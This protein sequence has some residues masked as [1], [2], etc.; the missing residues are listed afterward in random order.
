MNSGAVTSIPRRL[1]TPSAVLLAVVFLP[2]ECEIAA[3]FLLIAAAGQVVGWWL[4]MPR[5]SVFDRWGPLWIAT[6]FGGIG[7]ALLARG[8]FSATLFAAGYASASMLALAA[9][10]GK[11]M[12]GCAPETPFNRLALAVCG[13]LTGSYA[14]AGLTFL[15]RL[16]E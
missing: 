15:P 3:G 6:F 12:W 8:L 13:L 14:A 9:L 11:P 10:S 16:F 2:R 4:Y 7:L 5:D 1:L